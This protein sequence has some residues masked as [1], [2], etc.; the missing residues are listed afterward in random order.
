MIVTNTSFRAAPWADVLFAPDA[1]W[2]SV[3][4]DEARA[5]FAGERWTSD[6]TVPDANLIGCV[7]EPGLSKHP[8][9][10]HFGGNVGYMALGLAFLFGAY[11]MILLGYDM[12]RTGGRNHHH[13]D[14]D[15]G[16]PNL[17]NDFESWRVR[18]R[19]LAIDLREAGV[20]VVNATRE[21]ALTCFERAPLERAL[22]CTC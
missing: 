21:T 2:W 18:M 11:R 13:G 9:R 22:E 6:P 12:Q 4:G 14:H 1:R 15:G 16:L 17:T 7:D 5:K 20:D 10:V 8:E 3:Y 19:R